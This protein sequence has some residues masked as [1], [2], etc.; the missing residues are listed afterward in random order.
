MQEDV[1]PNDEAAESSQGRVVLYTV[2]LLVVVA[3]V[4]LFG[5]ND[6]DVPAGSSLPE[7]AP[8]LS[9]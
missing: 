7:Q 4:F 8:V 6:A 9:Q 3:V 2:I 1:S 5:G